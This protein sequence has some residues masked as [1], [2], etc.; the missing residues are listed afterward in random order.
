MNN[1]VLLTGAKGFTGKP[2]TEMLIKK[3]YKVLSLDC[4]ITNTSNLEEFLKNTQP[5]YV[6]HLA[7]ISNVSCKDRSMINKVNV[8]GTRNLLN[9][10][11]KMVN[12][13]KLVV[14]ASSAYVYAALEN[15]ILSENSALAPSNS[16]GKSKL[17]ME[18]L[19]EGYKNLKILITRPFNYTGIGQDQKFLIPKIVDHFKLKKKEIQLGNINVRREF[20]DISDVCKI[21]TKFLENVKFS[22]TV[23]ICSGNSHSIKDIIQI[24]EKLTSHKIRVEVDPKLKRQIDIP[25]IIGN[26]KKLN[27]LIGNYTF[28]NL[29]NTIKDMLFSSN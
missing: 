25:N 4:D 15:S 18:L 1:L 16:Y 2:L 26:P 12:Y 29:E 8:E 10:I 5:D 19:C 13:P 20:N 6:I 27:F 21:Y 7:A 3:K 23:N 11:N 17:E 14:I 22:N 9:N 28:K 24:C